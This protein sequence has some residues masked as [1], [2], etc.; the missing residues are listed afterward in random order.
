MKNKTLLI[1]LLTTCFIHAQQKID[2]Y[3]NKDNFQKINLSQVAEKIT[4]IP[5][6][7]TDESLLSEELQIFYAKDDIF[8]GDQQTGL[9]Y[10][11]DKSGKFLNKIGRKG[12]GPEDYPS[13]IYFYVDEPN[14]NILLISP[15]TKTLYQYTFEGIFQRKITLEETP[16]MIEKVSGQYLFFNQRFNRIEN[17]SDVK[18]LYLADSN[19]KIIQTMPTTIKDTKMDMLLFEM[20]FFYRYNEGIYYKNPL[21]DIVYEVVSPLQLKPVYEIYTG[22]MIRSKN[23]LRNPQNLQQQLSVRNMVETD[24]LLILIYAYQNTFY[25][26]LVNKKDGSLANVKNELPGLVEDLAGGPDFSPYWMA[27]S[28]QN[29]LL[30]LLTTDKIERQQQRF[31]HIITTNPRLIDSKKEN[32]PVLVVATLK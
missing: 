19:G 5:L 11:F 31:N 7:V 18:E 12:D 4:Y 21:L 27:S 8:V 2:L 24:Q 15:Q 29:V 6:E 17:Q 9:F 22:P 25:T 14:R 30:S 1:F 13:A 16:W 28:S 3:G 20:P 26:L 32:N 10:R 23:D